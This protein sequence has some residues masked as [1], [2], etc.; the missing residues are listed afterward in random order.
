[1]LAVVAISFKFG[2]DN[3]VVEMEKERPQRSRT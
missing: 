1:M 3:G 2:I